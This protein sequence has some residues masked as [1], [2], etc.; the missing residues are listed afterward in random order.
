M[1]MLLRG[2]LVAIIFVS[3]G[4]CPPVAVAEEQADDGSKPMEKL[5]ATALTAE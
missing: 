4:V 1:H 5:A 2:L 3:T